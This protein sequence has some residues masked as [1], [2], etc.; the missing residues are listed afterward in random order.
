MILVGLLWARLMYWFSR[1]AR[2]ICV[3][4]YRRISGDDEPDDDSVPVITDRSAFLSSARAKLLRALEHQEALDTLVAD[5][6]RIEAN[7]PRVGTR[8]ES[9]SGEHIVYA[10]FMPQLD[11]FFERAS[12]ITGDAIHNLRATLDHVIYALADRHTKGNV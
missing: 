4:T 10:S 6:F 2:A 9:E 12:L 7:R 5:T 3:F 8:Y 1:Q 11:D